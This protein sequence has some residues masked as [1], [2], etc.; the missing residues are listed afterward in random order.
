[1][2]LIIDTDTAGDDCFSLLLAMKTPGVTLE[3][4]TICNGNVDF[5]QQAENALATI[6][7]AGLSGQVP[8]YLGARKPL[9]AEWEPAQMHGADGMSGANLPRARQRPEDQHAVDALIERIMA[10]PGEIEMIAQAPLTN[11]ALAVTKEPRIAKALKHLWIMGG[12]DNSVGNVTPCA[13][14]NFYVDPEAAEIVFRAGFDITVSTWT[15]TM[16]ASTFDADQLARLDALETPLSEFY[17]KVSDTPRKVALERYGRVIC[18]HPDTLTCACAI[19]PSIIRAARPA[20]VRIETAGKITR[21]F[22]AMH[23]AKLGARWPEYH[24]NARIIEDAD[25]TAFFAMLERAFS[26]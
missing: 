9:L 8:V 3:A 2:R 5:D 14:F 17:R 1:M 23:P 11:L 18:T 22:S 10:A 15:L 12:T 13:E 19:D 25:N 26:A 6:E 4:V 16:R 24:D 7:A 21:G 20:V